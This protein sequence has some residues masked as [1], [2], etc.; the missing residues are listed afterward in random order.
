MRIVVVWLT[1]KLLAMQAAFP[2]DVPSPDDLADLGGVSFGLRPSFTRL[3]K[4]SS[5]R[6]PDVLVE[7]E[8]VLGVV[9]LLGGD[10]TRV[11]FAES[12]FH[13]ILTF[14][15]ETREVEV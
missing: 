3:G 15:A 13:Q 6:R 7:T 10:E 1:L 5:R 14:F 11:V 4:R 8:K 9:F 2:V 12:A